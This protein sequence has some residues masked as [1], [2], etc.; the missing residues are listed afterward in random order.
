MVEKADDIWRVRMAAMKATM[1]RKTI[2]D[3]RNTCGLE[4][5]CGS[6]SITSDEPTDP[7]D[8]E[9]PILAPNSLPGNQ[10]ACNS[11]RNYDEIGRRFAVRRR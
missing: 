3:S 6:Y 8:L 9:I 5:L 1:A 2:I 4:S 11:N 7:K 10:T